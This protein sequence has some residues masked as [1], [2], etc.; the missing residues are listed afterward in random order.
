VRSSVLFLGLIVAGL[1]PASAEVTCVFASNPSRWTLRSARLE[2]TWELTAE[3]RFSL[4]SLRDLTGGDRWDAAGVS[5]PIDIRLGEARVDGETRFRLTGQECTAIAGGK[6]LHI[7]L[8]DAAKLAEV[9]TVFELREG[10]AV[11]RSQTRVRPA[12]QEFVTN[13]GFVAFSLASGPARAFYPN[14]WQRP[15]P[16]AQSFD[17]NETALAQPGD[18]AEIRSGAYARH[19]SYVALRDGGDRGLFL[20]WEFD[21]R[22]TVRVE[23]ASDAVRISSEIP[24]MYHGVEAGQWFAGPWAFAGLF[25]GDWDDAGYAVQRFA[26]AAIAKP[27]PDGPFPYVMWDSWQYLQ[28]L[29]EETLR[30][31]AELAAQLGIE[32]FVVDL[33]WARDLGDWRPDPKKFPSGLKALSDYVHSLGMKFGLHFPLAEAGEASDLMNLFPEWRSSDRYFYFGAESL[34]LSHQPARDWVI[35]EGIRII[36]EYG[37]DWILQDGENMVKRCKD[38]AHTHHPGDSNYANSVDGL[39]YVVAAI[40]K[41]RPE[42][43]WENCENGGNMQ[44]FNMVRQYHTSI[45]SD[46]SGPLTTRRAVHAMSYVFPMRYT[47]RYM[48]NTVFSTY[49]T[50]SYMFGGPW[51]FMNRL[52]EM[53]GSELRFAASEVALYKQLRERLRDGRVFHLTPAP[54][55][56]FIDAIESYD[57]AT[58]SA[59]VFAYRW[60]NRQTEVQVKLRGLNPG[61]TYRVRFDHS[62][63]VLTLT[64]AALLETGLRVPVPDQEAEIAWIE[65]LR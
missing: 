4:L 29:N 22:A 19:M 61:R 17:L 13:A 1:T 48:P 63:Q 40:Q 20:G 11:V 38:P 21:G 64:G 32:V 43:I 36:D 53:D 28:D 18:A 6:A 16:E 33:G 42:V 44:T 30:Q 41:A 10:H 46:D 62:R 47:D 50:R 14:Q 55:G 65:P 26:E 58:D 60:G 39:N 23:R 7:R 8:E 34:C 57:P 3:G 54:D 51:I 12:H 35:S 27:R 31:N 5:S 25:H 59:L 45:T 49:I 9:E 37:V 56:T 15:D 24:E 52:P 2:A